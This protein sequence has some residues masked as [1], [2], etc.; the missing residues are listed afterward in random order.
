MVRFFEIVE[1]KKKGTGEER[2]LSSGVME[3]SPSR[4]GRGLDGCGMGASTY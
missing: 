4:S 1:G 2:A 3:S